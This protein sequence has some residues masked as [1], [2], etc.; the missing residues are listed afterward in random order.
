MVTVQSTVNILSR[1]YSD[2]R[3]L[4]SLFE[5]SDELEVKKKSKI[6]LTVWLLRRCFASLLSGHPNV[7]QWTN[8]FVQKPVWTWRRLIRAQSAVSAVPRPAASLAVGVDVLPAD[9][10]AACCR[11][12]CSDALIINVALLTAPDVITALGLV[13]IRQLLAC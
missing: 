7:R 3:L 10:P 5:H 1:L 12:C 8:R 9:C 4:L 13:F 6:R 2:H 11:G